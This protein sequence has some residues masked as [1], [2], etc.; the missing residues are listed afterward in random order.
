MQNHRGP[1]GPLET[2][3]GVCAVASQF[4][5]QCGDA[6]GKKPR[7][8]SL[9]RKVLGAL[10]VPLAAL[11]TSGAMAAGAYPERP[12]KIVVPFAA[13]GFTDIAARVIGQQLSDILGQPFVVENRAG[14]GS[15]IGTDLVAKAAPDGYTLGLIS[16]NHVT[17]HHL[18][19]NLAYDPLKS[20]TP[21]AKVA[22]SPYVLL[23][24]S[25]VKANSVQ[26]LIELSKKTDKP[27]HYGTS[28]NGST[29]HLMGALFIDKTGAKME[30]V[31]YRGSAQAMQDLAA[32]F[33]DVSFAAIS[34]SL[35]Q[36]KAGNVRAL[37][38]TSLKRSNYL[39]D[40]PSL[41]EAGV[42]GY[43]GVVWL[44]LVGPKGMPQEAV[45]K[46]NKAVH[47]ALAK[48][49][50]IDALANAGVDV[51]LS[52]PKELADYMVQEETLWGNVIRGI[53]IKID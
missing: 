9:W 12:V 34:N 6:A 2:T 5:R 53:N 37:A 31:P 16:S 41:D 44:A 1:E 45:D 20:F 39:P 24:N 52:G 36:L 42:K 18:Y 4:K 14:A 28:G 40:V 8:R 25:K 33:V 21:I 35:P 30:H 27:L 51:S 32:G 17:S 47:T 15:T 10:V 23:V 43:E 29:Q 46:L 22:D 48:K 7:G 19:K 49:E 50:A 38:V 26:E 11:S 3:T 13:G